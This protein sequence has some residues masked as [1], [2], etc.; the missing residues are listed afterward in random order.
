MSKKG[1]VQA[2]SS[3]GLMMKE[4]DT[5]IMVGMNSQTEIHVTGT[6]EPGYL[7]PKMFVEFVADL[8]AT[9]ESKDKIDKLSIC[10]P[11]S[12]RP[13]G[14]SEPLPQGDKKNKNDK[15]APAAAAPG[16]DNGGNAAGKKTSG[17]NAFDSGFDPSSSKSKTHTSGPKLPGTFTVRGTV[18]SYKNGK[19]MVS[20]G[21]GP[22]VKVDISDS[23]TIDVDVSDMRGVSQGDKVTVK[24]QGIKN[25]VL[26][27]SI[28][29]EMSN[30]LTG[31]KKK[32]THEKPSKMPV[33]SNS[34]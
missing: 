28:A 11:S 30:P 17:K 34:K 32:T 13:A 4:G 16:G 6:A 1:T 14:L 27:A 24:G 18:K 8:S 9:G 25:Q 21:H 19:L 33:N 5:P 23:A 20:T 29:I 22:I 15:D 12:D 10:S 31:A 2:V 26:A 7:A 3:S